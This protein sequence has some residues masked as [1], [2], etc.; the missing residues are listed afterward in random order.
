MSR[1]CPFKMILL[2]VYCQINIYK[3]DKRMEAYLLTGSVF[4]FIIA[5][6]K[7]LSL[8]KFIR[9]L[10][11]KKLYP[12]ATIKEIESFEKNTKH[13]YSSVLGSQTKHLK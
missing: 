5:L 10:L 6:F 1:F 12:K 9:L 7:V 4:S 2:N 13:N 3:K 8:G 11:L